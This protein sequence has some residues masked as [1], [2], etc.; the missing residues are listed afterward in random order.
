MIK[1]P[2]DIIIIKYC[3]SSSQ[4]SV[5]LNYSWVRD[6]G[7]PITTQAFV[8]AAAGEEDMV[9]CTVALCAFAQVTSTVMFTWNRP[10]QIMRPH[11]TSKVMQRLLVNSPNEYHKDTSSFKT[12]PII[13]CTEIKKA[14]NQGYHYNL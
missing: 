7:G 10:K 13:S 1:N 2:V 12:L 11:L 5:Y 6:D 14:N 3:W 8:I 9:G 4:D